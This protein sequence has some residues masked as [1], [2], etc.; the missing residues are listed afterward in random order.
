MNIAII[1][2]N[3]GNIHSIQYAL[4]RL[5][6]DAMVTD[7]HEQIKNSDKIIF[8]GV[9]NAYSAMES[10]KEKG[11]DQLL[12]SCLQPVLG[13]CVG[14][15]LLC[16]HS[17]ENNT[18]GLGI[19]DLSVKKFLPN[20]NTTK[21]PHMGWNNLSN[22]KGPLFEGLIND[23]FVY[24]VHSY[25]VPLAPETIASTNY[26]HE[27]SAVIQKNNFY[28]VQFH[29]EKSSSIGDKILSNFLNIV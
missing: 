10:L 19:M 13:I 11:L 1:K 21:V 15:Q 24:Y 3:A 26:I 14:M 2:Y 9:G 16:K 6:Y 28:G 12:I 23:P 27:Y 18:T 4:K 5:G 8:P 7:D 20:D 17:E 29:T 22:M 25:Y